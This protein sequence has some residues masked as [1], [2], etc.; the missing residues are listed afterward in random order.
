MFDRLLNAR[1]KTIQQERLIFVKVISATIRSVT[2]EK[3]LS[4]SIF[5]FYTVHD[6]KATAV[7]MGV[8]TDHS[9]IND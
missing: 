5:F 7:E 8:H 2:K 3:L 1:M 6:E 9:F 4:R